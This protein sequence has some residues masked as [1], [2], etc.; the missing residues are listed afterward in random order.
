M[1]VDPERLEAARARLDR[2]AAAAARAPQ[3][4]PLEDGVPPDPDPGD[5][6]YADDLVAAP[7]PPPDD[8]DPPVEAY[9]DEPTARGLKRDNGAAPTD[10]EPDVAEESGGETRPLDWRAL[11]GRTPPLRSWAIE[12]WLAM[13]HVTLMAGE[14][15]SGKTGVA[16]AL[17][18][19]LA[20]RREYL[21]WVPTERRVIM[22]A[23]EDDTDELWRRQ[24]AIA[25]WLDVPLAAFA[26]RL[27]CEQQ[28]TQ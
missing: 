13:G 5:Y 3:Q 15:G 26:E 8:E 7:G 21:D 1:G 19:C 24:V 22:W 4:S 2:E 20:L 18:S 25:K 6:A 9:V 14:G 12:Y 23:C 11:D 27:H 16:Q 28:D 17:G 10:R